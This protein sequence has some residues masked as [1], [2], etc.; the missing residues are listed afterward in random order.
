MNVTVV[1]AG[2]IGLTTAIRLR[3]A[4]FAADIVAAELPQET[5]ASRNAGAIWYPYGTAHDDRVLEW[6]RTTLETFYDQRDDGVGLRI[7]PML[8]VLPSGVGDPWWVSSVRHYRRAVPQELPA[9][10]VDG[11]VVEG[12]CIDPPRYLEFL[13][14]T[15][16]ALGGGIEQR[17]IGSLDEVVENGSMAINCTGAAAGSLTDDL[18][19]HPVRG[20]LVRIKNP[21]IDRVTID[22][23]GPLAI[24]YCI[25]HEDECVLGGTVE[26][27]EWDLTPD[28][29]VTRAIIEKCT[30]LEPAI[31][32]PEIVDV[33][34]GL[35]PGR[36][37]VRLEYEPSASGGGVIH[38]YGHA[39]AGWTLSWG[40]AGSVVRLVEEHA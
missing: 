3:E 28:P 24:A 8:E 13:T 2:I 17:R 4:G 40:C 1:G 12:A 27:G 39:G 23:R 15:F 31:A 30:I 16:S 10:Y 9:G 38:N 25:P 18:D 20:Q 32:H 33:R 21:G 14:E 22:E 29:A 19:I 26:P 34:V 6:G 37:D 36:H 7:V 35:R 11:W 5:P